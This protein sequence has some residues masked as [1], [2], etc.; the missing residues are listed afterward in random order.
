MI[1]CRM[2]IKSMKFFLSFKNFIIVSYM[3]CCVGCHQGI[4][5]L[6]EY[7]TEEPGYEIIIECGILV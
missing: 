5:P 4:P 2:S 3:I 1:L 7:Q 6:Q